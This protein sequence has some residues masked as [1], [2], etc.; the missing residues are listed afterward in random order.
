MSNINKMKSCSDTITRLVTENNINFSKENR[1]NS[2]ISKI[3]IIIVRIVEM[4]LDELRT[5]INEVG[6]DIITLNKI[7]SI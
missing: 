2:S 4:E 6:K 1:I 7:R 5:I 3:T